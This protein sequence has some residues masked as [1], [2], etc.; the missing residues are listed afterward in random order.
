MRRKPGLAAAKRIGN[1]PRALFE[2]KVLGL[3]PN[4]RKDKKRR[5]IKLNVRKLQHVIK[6]K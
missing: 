2:P 1:G 4:E 6:I 3:G 5:M